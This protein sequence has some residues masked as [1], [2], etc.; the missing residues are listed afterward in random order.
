MLHFLHIYTPRQQIWVACMLA[1]AVFA[2]WR[3]G[4]AERT[5]AWGMVV[6]SVGSGILQ[7]T[8]DWAAPQWAD[9][10]LD[11]IYLA[12]MVWVALKSDRLWTLWVAAFQ[13]VDVF[14]YLAHSVNIRIGGRAPN[15]AILIYSYLI[16]IVIAVGT[17]QHWQDRPPG[18]IAPSPSTGTSAT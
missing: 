18:R 17:W 12:L 1:V 15:A 8:R 3:G 11:V 6:D 2:Q 16:L 4:W 5:I 7:N 14:I 9:L 13:L 10:G